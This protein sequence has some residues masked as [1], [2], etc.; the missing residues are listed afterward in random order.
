M[1]K[2]KITIEIFL[3]I[4][5]VKESTIKKN[6][7]KIPGLTYTNGT[8]DILKGTGIHAITTGIKSKIPPTGGICYKGYQRVQ[9]YRRFLFKRLSRTVC[10]FYSRF[11]MRGFDQRK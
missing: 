10:R 6:R 9:E 11:I 5:S 3:K 4:A 1:D 7:D 2:E 8:Y